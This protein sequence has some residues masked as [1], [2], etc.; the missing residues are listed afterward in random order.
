M[1]Y[2]F[3]LLRVESILCPAAAMFYYVLNSLWYHS[4]SHLSPHADPFVTATD[5]IITQ[6]LPS[7]TAF[8]FV[9]N[10]A[11][12]L[13]PHS[14]LFDCAFADW[15]LFVLVFEKS[16]CVRKMFFFL[17]VS[18]ASLVFWWC[19]YFFFCLTVR[20]LMQFQ[21]VLECHTRD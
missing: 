4:L 12:P 3:F 11:C 17:S 2:C 13:S 21:S 19:A 7:P 5:L 10:A 1:E 20:K 15:S 9:L 8:G 18:K 14:L 16:A 6:Y